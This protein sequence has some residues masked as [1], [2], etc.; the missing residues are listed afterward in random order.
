MLTH[1]ALLALFRRLKA[2][3]ASEVSIRPESLTRPLLAVESGFLTQ[4]RP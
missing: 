3:E 1:Q 2:L 4:T